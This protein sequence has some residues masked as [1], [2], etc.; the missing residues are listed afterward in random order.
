SQLLDAVKAVRREVDRASGGALP[1]VRSVFVVEKDERMQ[2]AIRDM[3]KQQGYRVFVAVD[4]ARALDRFR[5]Q[6]YDALVVDAGTTGEEGRRVFGNVLSEAAQKHFPCAAI[7]ILSKDQAEWAEHVPA[8]RNSAV[9]VMPVT[10]K[11]LRRKL[12]EL[13]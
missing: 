10:S 12:R 4:P 11:Q 6:P 9:L 3:L 13:L 2:T 8:G 5:Q 7:L 1:A